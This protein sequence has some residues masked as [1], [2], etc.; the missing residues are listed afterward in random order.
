MPWSRPVRWLRT[1]P[2]HGQIAALTLLLAYGWS[3]LAFDYSNPSDFGGFIRTI[4]ALPN[5][6]AFYGAFDL[7]GNGTTD[8]SDLSG[9]L[10]AWGDCP[11]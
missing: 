8:A 5:R 9:I 6:A 2:R 1:D 7:N 4:D 3:Q 11:P 10:G